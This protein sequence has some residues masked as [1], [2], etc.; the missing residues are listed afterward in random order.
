[1]EAA[2]M[3]VARQH[4]RLPRGAVEPAHR[5]GIAWMTVIVTACAHRDDAGSIGR[6]EHRTHRRQRS[7]FDPAIVLERLERAK[8]LIVLAR[9]ED[10]LAERMDRTRAARQI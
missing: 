6:N 8:V 4:A 3:R 1:M 7:Q 2:E 9:R 10:A 5:R